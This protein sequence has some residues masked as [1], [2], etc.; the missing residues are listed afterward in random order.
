[1]CSSDLLVEGHTPGGRQH[2]E[3]LGRSSGGGHRPDPL[4]FQVTDKNGSILGNGD[5][6]R[7]ADA[8]F[9]EWSGLAIECDTVDLTGSRIADQ[10]SSLAIAGDAADG[11][12]RR[13]ELLLGQIGRASCRERV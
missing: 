7:D 5:P 3:L 1:M 2:G 10:Q 9:C 11:I 12:Q 8:T 6:H 13:A 4:Q